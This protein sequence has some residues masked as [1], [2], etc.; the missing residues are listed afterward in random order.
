MPAALISLATASEGCAPLPSHSF[1]FASSSSIV[2][3][4]VCGL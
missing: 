2:E 3:G 4:S 1:T